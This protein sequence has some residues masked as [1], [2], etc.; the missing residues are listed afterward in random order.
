MK[1]VGSTTSPYVRRIRLYLANHAYEFVNIDIFASEDRQLLTANNPAQKVPA[2][3]DGDLSI[4]DSRV[5][6]RYL[7][8]QYQEKPLTWQ[9]ENL[10]TLIDAANDSLVSLLL[11]DRSAIDT[12]QQTL[13]FNLQH[14]RIENVLTSLEKSV[15][16]QEFEQWHYPSICLYCLLDWVEFRQLTSLTAYPALQ[17]FLYNNQHQQDVALTNPRA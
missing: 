17:E 13:F 4:Y 3:I 15:A 14:Q 5:I 12:Q 9:Q 1:L 16:Q 7:A 6:Y 11:L 2:L 10:L 8:E